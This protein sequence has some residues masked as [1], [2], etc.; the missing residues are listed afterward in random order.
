MRRYA[1]IPKEGPIDEQLARALIHGYYAAVSQTDAL[2]GRVIN[3]LDR[4]GLRENTVII[5][6]GDHGW[7]LGEHGLWAKH[8]NF[9]T[10]LRSPLIVSG[11]GVTHGKSDA[12]VEF[13]DLYPTVVELAGLNEP[14]HSL[15]GSSL[16]PMLKGESLQ[17]DNVAVSKWMQGITLIT[18]RYSYTE[19]HDSDRN[20]TARMLYDHD[21]APQENINVSESEDYREVVASLSEK[22]GGYLDE[23]YWAPAVGE[24]QHRGHTNY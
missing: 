4:L 11:Q 10:A 12:V 15:A 14:V 9:D 22:L 21:V 19:W 17:G 13:V 3:E 7:S 2:I 18:P 6:V 24:Y 16:V 20:Q 5:L 8:V 1:N 23:E